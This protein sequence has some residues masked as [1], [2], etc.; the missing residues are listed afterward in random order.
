MGSVGQGKVSVP[1]ARVE[2]IKHFRKP[3]TKTDVRTFLGIV[4]YYRRF[5]PQ[6]SAH[7]YPLTEATKKNSPNV[8]VWTDLMY[9]SFYYLCNSLSQAS[10]LVIPNSHDHF[11]LHT[12]ASAHGIGAVLS[13]VRNEG[14]LPTGYF[15]RKLS[16]MEWNYSATELEC[17]VV[18]KSVEHSEVHLIGKPLLLLLT[19]EHLS[20]WTPLGI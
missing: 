2:A 13:V 10:A 18:V 5:I 1:E 12:D 20:T 3:M 6:F 16:V 9:Q 14:Q 15:S 4:G 19:T 8:I 11:V 17:L 7:A